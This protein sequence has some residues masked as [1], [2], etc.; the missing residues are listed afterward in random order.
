MKTSNRN[1]MPDGYIWVGNTLRQTAEG[2]PVIEASQGSSLTGEIL[3]NPDL[4][5]QV[6]DR[7][8]FQ[9]G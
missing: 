9:D 7:G 3:E 8:V 1:L 5:N 2:C 6:G 4:G